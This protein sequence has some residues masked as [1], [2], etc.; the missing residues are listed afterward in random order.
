LVSFGVHA[1]L[2][3][4]IV[5]LLQREAGSIPGMRASRGACEQS[6]SGAY[7][8]AYS[9]MTSGGADRHSS[10][11]AHRSPNRRTAHGVLRGGCLGIDAS[12]PIS[13]LPAHAVIGDKNF[14]G[15]SRRRH[16]R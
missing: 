10:D 9:G 1:L 6:R 11:S 3:G 14:E 12:L 8:C 15:F 5:A 7:A 4:D 13:K 2:V 16:H